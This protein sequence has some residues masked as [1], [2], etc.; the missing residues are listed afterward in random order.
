MMM[1]M[2]GWQQLFAILCSL[3]TALVITALIIAAHVN[4]KKNVP[5]K[6]NDINY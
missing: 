5:T 6:N 1:T 4:D 3:S 2:N